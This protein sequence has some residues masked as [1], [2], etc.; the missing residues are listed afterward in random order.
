[1]RI[2]LPIGLIA[3]VVAGFV[4]LSARADAQGLPEAP[5]IFSGAVTVDGVP[6]PDGLMVHARVGDYRSDPVEV[7]D[8]RYER[9]N[10]KP[11]EPR[12]HGKDITFYL[13]AEVLAAET[14]LFYRTS[15][16]VPE[17]N[18]DLTFPNLPAPT[19]TPTPDP[20]FITPTVTPTPTPAI[21]DAMTF[22]WGG[23]LLNEGD[24]L[25]EGAR[26]TARVGGYESR[27]VRIARVGG[28]YEYENLTV[29][30]RAVSAIG[31]TVLF[32]I[33]G[34]AA[35]TTTAFAGGE[36]RQ[37]FDIRFTLALA[38]PTA[39]PT[40][41]PIPTATPTP[42]ATATATP[43]PTP[44]YMMSVDEGGATVISGET[45]SGSDRFTL[46]A[47]VARFD[48]T[49]AGGGRFEVDLIN[50]AGQSDRLLSASGAYAGSVVVGVH[51][52]AS[53]AR[54]GA[55]VPGG[56]ALRVI[57]DGAW[58]VKVSQPL[59]ESGA[60]GVIF[61]T[62]SGDAVSDP[63]LLD[64]PEIE[65]ELSH[66]GTGEF[67]VRLLAADGRVVET[68]A[69]GTGNYTI[70]TVVEVGAGA[71]DPGVYGLAVRAGGDWTISAGPAAP[72][73]TA[74]PEPTATPL[75]TA[76][77]EPTA[78]PDPTATPEPTAEPE[79]TVPPV[80]SGGG[81]CGSAGPVSPGAAAANALLLLAPLG[82]VAWL[83][84]RRI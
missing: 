29:D 45:S 32:F 31:G 5:Y 82:A 14:Y 39:T 64:W 16:P 7:V 49:H 33:E 72:D 57:A 53:G 11:E 68:L 43:T 21:P 69:R 74:T 75:P 36:T 59:W 25:P 17:P 63:V 37:G 4:A 20:R 78:T 1:M 23:V 61:L 44:S 76:T 30:P 28:G 47:G 46:D 65:V 3:I 71:L 62:G 19:P 8:G 52:G 83:R 51:D 54:A 58:T 18:F 22:A 9:L 15:I 56:Y 80:T 24:A 77:P 66:A 2:I 50:A 34:K 73:P 27:P 10:V 60:S 35:Q 40:A 70:G 67:V 42:T 6:A 38:T 55:V 84:R 48:M 81:G 79:P 26:L 12:F 13:G 41:T